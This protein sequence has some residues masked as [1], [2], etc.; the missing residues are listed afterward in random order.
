MGMDNGGSIYLFQII[1]FNLNN[2]E[3]TNIK[4]TGK[5]GTIF[6]LQINNTFIMNCNMDNSI[7]TIGSGGNIFF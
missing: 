1:D 5:G 2:C 4:A 7:L 3:F 6:L